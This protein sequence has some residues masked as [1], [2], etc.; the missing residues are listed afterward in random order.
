MRTITRNL[1][2][3][4]LALPA[5]AFANGDGDGCWKGKITKEKKI[6][7][8]YV[9]NNNAALNVTNK[10]GTVYVTTWDENQTVI[11]VVIKVNG[12]KEELV[13][14]RLNSI[15]INFEATTALVR[16]KTII[17]NFSGNVNMEINYTIKIPKKGSI[18]ISN[19]Y[20]NTIVGKIYGRGQL[21]CQYG[22]LSVDELNSDTNS[23]NLQY[24][25]TSKINYIKSAD[26]NVQY[27][28]FNVTKAGSLKLKGQYTGMTIGEVQNI[29]YKTEYGDLN[30]K[31]GGN[32]TGAGDYSALRFGYVTGQVN[33]TCNYGEVKVGGMDNDVK[34]ITINATYSAVTITYNDAAPF[35]FEFTTEYGGVRGISGFKLTDKKEKDNKA[36]YKGYYKSSGVNKIFIRSEYGDINLTKG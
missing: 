3:L 6:S 7:K 9:V 2:L 11:D 22:D 15:D 35:D 30:I 17:G 21:N 14:R 12:D 31:K 19:Q 16:A 26:V 1:I 13:T 8:S 4:L 25:G 34:N 5:L 32:M 33:A 28:G 20:G 27:S 18:D 23:I 36:Y 24:S 29:T 10:Y